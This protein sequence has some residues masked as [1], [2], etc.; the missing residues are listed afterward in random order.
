MKDGAMSVG[1]S[2][3]GGWWAAGLMTIVSGVM[4]ALAYMF[5][6]VESKS[7]DAICELRKDVKELKDLC[8][9]QQKD[10]DDCKEDRS[11]LKTEVA[12]LKAMHGKQQ[13]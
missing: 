10:I 13:Q 12:I 9:K 5:K 6:L 3:D 2:D 1:N 11:E 8:G 7:A 4:G